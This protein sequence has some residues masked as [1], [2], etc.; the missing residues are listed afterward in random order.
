MCKSRRRSKTNCEE[1][2]AARQVEDHVLHRLSQIG[3]G[4]VSKK[5]TPP[6][7]KSS[8]GSD[9]EEKSDK[10]ASIVKKYKT[11]K[12][13]KFTPIEPEVYWDPSKNSQSFEEWIKEVWGEED[14]ATKYLYNR[15][16]PMPPMQCKHCS[17]NGRLIEYD[18]NTDKTR[19]I[20]EL[21]QAC[22]YRGLKWY[23]MEY[24]F[25]KAEDE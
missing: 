20:Y 17:E 13:Q 16:W 1:D 10:K 3:N 2:F 14:P 25:F 12:K 19:V 9:T 24:K 18:A 8:E 15:W 23:S 6:R 11:P 22:R 4:A 7:R 5:K 21:C